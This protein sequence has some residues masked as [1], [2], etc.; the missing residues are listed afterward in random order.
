MTKDPSDELFDLQAYFEH[1]A[2]NPIH[3]EKDEEG[4][5]P[6]QEFHH[7]TCKNSRCT[8]C[9]FTKTCEVFNDLADMSMNGF[10]TCMAECD[11]YEPVKFKK[12]FTKKDFK[13][14]GKETSS[15]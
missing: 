12:T 6:E 10:H 2:E 11:Q 13:D 5:I 3:I 8:T 1:L 7:S 9:K 15:N 4:E 14:R